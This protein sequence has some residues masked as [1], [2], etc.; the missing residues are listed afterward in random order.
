[1]DGQP[2]PQP[3]PASHTDDQFVNTDPLGATQS[4][5]P[6]SLS[7]PPCKVS[8]LLLPLHHSQVCFPLITISLSP[9][10]PAP[11]IP[12]PMS[13][14]PVPHP[15]ASAVAGLPPTTPT[16]SC[17]SLSSPTPPVPAL[18]ILSASAAPL[19]ACSMSTACPAAP[20][21][22]IATQSYP[23]NSGPASISTFSCTPNLVPAVVLTVPGSAHPSV[24]V[25]PPPVSAN[26]STDL[27]LRF[28]FDELNL[29]DL[30]ASFKSLFKTM[31]ER[32]ASQ[33]TYL[34][35]FGF[36]SIKL[37]LKN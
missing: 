12:S 28:T 18:S 10:Q 20:S 37:N 34:M 19:P 25:A 21:Y 14:L 11:Y 6:A 4:P 33:C 5:L 13:S 17:N 36:L 24:S 1:M 2:A 22:P 8:S 3:R 35:C 31:R 30:Y 9:Q 32:G 27:P 26:S 15:S 7:S 23:T 29:P 16:S